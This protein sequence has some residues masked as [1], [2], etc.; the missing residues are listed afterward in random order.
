VR[1]EQWT[2]E[3]ERQLRDLVAAKRPIG[4]IAESLGK[5]NES[6]LKMMRLGLVVDEQALF[7]V[8]LQLSL[9]CPRV[10]SA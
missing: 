4:V 7:R 5:S 2:A 9:S 1:R 3:E 6:V 8:Q 10:F